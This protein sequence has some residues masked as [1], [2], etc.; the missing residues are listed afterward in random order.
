MAVRRSQ[1]WLNQQRVDV[2]HLRSI[3]SAVRNDFDEL[4]SS[5][6]IGQSA[7]YI[8]RGWELNMV[9][10]I[11]ASASSLQMIV[12]NSSLF[13]GKSTQSGTFFQVATGVPNQTINSTT[14]TAVQGSFTP[15]ALNYIGIEFSRAVDNS[16][17][18]Q[19]FL[20]NP[21]NKNEISKTVP[22][23]ETLNYKIVVTSS[24]WA[25]NVLP[26]A[27]V[28]TDS[29]NNV[30]SVED[31]RPML[32]R[33]GSGG[34]NTPNPFY[35]YPWDH[36]AEGRTENFWKSTSSISPF[37]G[38]DKQIETE[39]EWKDAVMSMILEMKGTTY[40]YSPNA[41]GSI[42]KLRG[43]LA[44]LQ[45]TGT[46]KFSHAKLVPGQINWDSDIYLNYIGSRLSY[47]I[48]ANASSTDVILADGQVAYI[49]LVRGQDVIPNLIFTQGSAVV[50]SVGAVSWTSDVLANDYIKVG[51][52]D[53][54]KYYK[55]ASVD[56][57]SQV[58]LSEVFE[59]TSTG[60]G[61]T[62]AKYAY[63]TYQ[64]S[65]A[66]T[67]NRHMFVVDR[68]DVPFTEDNYWIFM[69]ED[70]GGSIAR[71]YIRGSSGGELQ[72]GED[73]EISDNTSIEVLEYIGAKSETDNEPDYTNALTTGVAE[74]RLLT[75]PAASALTG[76]QYFTINS[77]LDIKKYYVWANKSGGPALIS[78]PNWTP[79][80]SGPLSITDAT[81][82]Y[83]REITNSL[84]NFNMSS[85]DLRARTVGAPTG[86]VRMKIYGDA[87]GIPGTLLGTSNTVS[88]AALTAV[89]SVQNFVFSSP[90]ALLNS[91]T[92]HYAIEYTGAT[93]DGSNYV[94]FDSET[95]APPSTF[96]A[97]YNGSI[98]A[99]SAS[100]NLQSMQF[101]QT[102][103]SVDPLVPGLEGI[104]VVLT[105]SETNLQVAAAY[106]AVLDANPY[107][108]ST[109]N[110]DGSITVNNSQVGASTN[111][112][113]VNMASTTLT[114]TQE[115]GGSYN[116]VVVDGE[117]LTKSIKRLDEVVGE[118]QAALDTDPYQENITIVSGAPASDNEVTGP[119]SAGTSLTIP[120]NAR[121]SNIQETYVV[122]KADLEI[123][124]NGQQ[125][126]V[127]KD[128]TE[129]GVSGDDSSL[130]QF[131]FILTVDDVLDFRKISGTASGGG[132]SGA[133]SGV[134]LGPSAQG[135]VF[136]QTIGSQL[137]F[138]RLKQG[139]NITITQNVNDITISSSSGVAPTPTR[140]VNGVNSAIVS[141]DGTVHGINGGVNI[142]FTLP[143][144]TTVEGQFFYF[145]KRDTGN[146][147]FIK[148]VFSQTMDGVDIDAAP[149]PITLQNESLTIQAMGGAWWIA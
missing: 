123:H 112:A 34:P 5:Y 1:N 47:K 119:V 95:T 85:I 43:D 50:N 26:I 68:E 121:A 141:T 75:L 115:G 32:F 17:T 53:D 97:F 90:V 11:G 122:G 96:L 111:A 64:T 135:D 99:E 39:K 126:V 36:D 9:G 128:Y 8:I 116:N 20:W 66:P 48:L 49:N 4:I 142:T 25:A 140:L 92:Y 134:N 109:N 58:T 91:T 124:L 62:Q 77:A 12:E 6:V 86:N 57:A 29:S 15:S 56:T 40:W 144:A 93:I 27:I 80:G 22:L 60:S 136:K 78:Q 59:Q 52:E 23:A 125:L 147:L 102:T 31:R 132:G 129:V 21:T 30:L 54:T 70:N 104:P 13:H 89:Y 55:I 88:I 51:S 94:E 73:R 28:E 98:W 113:N 117:N 146:T 71:A 81:Y 87:A 79:V 72:Q 14:N 105:G 106:Q 63:G 131:T 41:G 45:M 84:G 82:S 127:G 149:K 110:F 3:E 33:L 2:P 35:V 46:G 114:T 61:G 67:T 133:A 16:T 100:N 76:G 139:A 42:T 145:K 137:Q 37:R 108:D 44:L 103:G 38:G 107:F 101:Y 24:I 120:L 19:V 69:R 130:V 148:S 7:S 18:A 138:R 143:D 10:A 83:A 118:V 65:P 74:E